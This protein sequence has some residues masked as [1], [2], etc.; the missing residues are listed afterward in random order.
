MSGDRTGRQIPGEEAG[1]GKL[2]RVRRNDGGV[3]TLAPHGENPLED[4]EPYPGGGQWGR[5]E[6]YLHGVLPPLPE[7]S[8]L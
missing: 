1:K 4:F 8:D 3:L 6:V 7:F 2:Q 5:G